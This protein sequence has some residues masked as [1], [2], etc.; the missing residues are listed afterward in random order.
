M[1][2]IPDEVISEI[3]DRVDIV[4]IIGEHVHLKKAGASWKGLCPFHGERTPSFHV[5]PAKRTYYCFGCQKHGD[6]Y[7]FLMEMQGKSFAEVVRELARACGVVIPEKPETPEER[8][9]KSEKARLFE[10][11]AIATAFYRE[12]LADAQ[13]GVTGRKYLASRG[14]ADA[15]CEIFQ[16]GLAPEA[17]DALAKRLEQRKVPVQLPVTLGLIAARSTKPGQEQ[18]RGY[19]DK[20]R[21]RLMCPVIM[22]GG[23]IAGFS[24][25]TLGSDPETPKYVNTPESPVYTK[26]HLLFGL[27]AARSAFRA[28]NRALLVEGNFDVI[29]LHQAGFSEAVAPLGT[30]LTQQ[31]VGILRR[32]A[33]TIT[34]CFD[35]DKA[36]RAAALKAIAIMIGAGLE[37]RVAALPDGEDPDSYVRKHGAAAFDALLA[38]AQPGFDWLLNHLW[39]ATKQTVDDRTAALREAAPILA[40]VKEPEKRIIVVGMFAKALGVAE[41]L[42]MR[43]IQQHEQATRA[44]AA[45]PGAAAAPATKPPPLPPKPELEL[46]ALLAD[47]PGLFPAAE[48]KNARDLLTDARLRDMYLRAASGIAG[49]P[50]MLELAP[51]ELRDV[52][53]RQGVAGKYLSLADPAKTLDEMIRTL[54]QERTRTKSDSLGREA[55]DA[56]RRGEDPDRVKELLM[57]QIAARK[58]AKA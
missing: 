28:K 22:P 11:N 48:A 18:A 15:V 7:A 50:S 43:V 20:F 4:A 55:K 47:H 44:A 42:V 54:H 39:Y 45:A 52:I 21:N 5:T 19:Y 36:G 31:Q 3:R 10:V 14:I 33:P 53:A 56:E 1:G 57:Q 58:K 8:A 30:A 16:L 6:V 26:S 34:V 35:G 12:Q 23:E 32:L 51:E 25:R 29:A 40:S 27:H 13:V 37:G 46:L 9:R 41:Q 38:K 49:G 2:L 17:W 24:G